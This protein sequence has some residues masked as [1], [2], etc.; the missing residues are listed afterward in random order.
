VDDFKEANEALDDQVKGFD[1]KKVKTEHGRF[2]NHKYKK[3]KKTFK[4]KVDS[5]RFNACDVEKRK[6]E[7]EEF[8]DEV[9]NKFPAKADGGPR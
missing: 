8:K 5:G 3:D 6:T 2:K 1:V 7:P 9:F 4:D